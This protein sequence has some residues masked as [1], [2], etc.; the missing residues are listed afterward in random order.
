MFSDSPLIS[1][2]IPAYMAENTLARALD[3]VVMQQ[4]DDVEV[5]VVDDGGT[6]RTAEIARSYAGRIKMNVISLARNSGAAAAFNHAVSA[7]RGRYICRLDAD[8]TLS[9]GL[10]DD[11]AQILLKE[12]PDIVRGGYNRLRDSVSTYVP[13]VRATD[14]NDFS[15]NVDH[16][17]LCWKFIRTD[18][19]TNADSRPFV[20]IDCWE[21]LGVLSRIFARRPSVIDVDRPFYT[22]YISSGKQSLSKSRRERLLADHLAMADRLSEWFDSRGLSERYGDFLDHLKF[23]AKVK[24]LRGRGRDVARWKNTYSE[25][26]RRVLS[27][28]HVAMVHRLL[29]ATVAILPTGLSQTISDLCDRLPRLKR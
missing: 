1:V 28:R 11:I 2:V 24:L 20:G 29:F 21:D 25:V 6:D 7:V 5:V 22:Y 23:A 15:I 9:T 8:D 4:F 3:S 12:S 10:F 13:V 19:L 26:N 16:F 18:L 27:L 14:L 17:S